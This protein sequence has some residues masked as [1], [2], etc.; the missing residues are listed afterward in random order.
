MGPDHRQMESKEVRNVLPN[1]S[2]A[3][4]RSGSSVSALAKALGVDRSA[5][6]RWMNGQG[7]PK[8]MEKLKQLADLLGV[9]IAYLVDEKDVPQTERQRS[10][11]RKT[12]GVSDGVLAAIEAMLDAAHKDKG[13]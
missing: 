1:L 12:A 3:V 9:S 7:G 13:G 10:I 5:F 2:A 8:S 11:L 6:Y 4:D